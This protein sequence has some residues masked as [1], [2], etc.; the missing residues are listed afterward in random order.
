MALRH[1]RLLAI[2]IGDTR[3]LRS[4]QMCTDS[5]RST[6]EHTCR[7]TSSHD[8]TQPQICTQVHMELMARQGTIGIWRRGGCQ[9]VLGD[10]EMADNV[11]IRHPVPPPSVHLQ[12]PQQVIGKTN[13]QCKILATKD[14]NGKP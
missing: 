5:H 4:T 8:L 14:K 7:S 9:P 13:N 6:Q 2:K 12:H 1:L 10:G 11:G 3:K